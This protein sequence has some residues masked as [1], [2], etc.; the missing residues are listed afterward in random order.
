MYQL[1]RQIPVMGE[2]DILVAGAGPAG[3]CAAM[4]AARAGARVALVERH[5]TV[6]GNLTLGHVGPIMGKLNPD[7]MAGEI[8]DL[9]NGGTGMVHD[10]E[11]AKRR[12]MNW[13]DH[14]LIDLYLLCPVVD[15][16]MEAGQIK[17]LVVGTQSGMAAIFARIV[18]DCTGDGVVSH[19]A[20]AP[21]VMGREGD[22]LV[23]PATI[24]YTIAGIDPRQTM[25]CTHE[26]DE[27]ILPDGKSYLQLCRDACADGR[28]PE[29]VNIVRLYRCADDPAKR[30][31][32]ATQE[33]R[34]N[35]LDP[36]DMVRAERSLRNQCQQ[37]VTFLREN[38]WGF[39]HCYIES[40]AD[41]VGI[42]ES[43]RVL[44]EY[45]ICGEDLKYGM[46][47]PDPVVHDAFFCIDIHNPDGAGQ[48]ES[49]NKPFELEQYDLPYRAFVPLNVEGLYTCG[50]CISGTHRAHASYRVMNTVLAMG[51][52]IGT[53]AALCVQENVLPR[54][55]DYSLL[56]R[57][58]TDMGVHLGKEA[59]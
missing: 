56:R 2:Y 51:Q 24:M 26:A 57:A 32:N 46:Q 4:A 52:A 59:P 35:A 9:L 11:D 50:R 55:L 40:S 19:L 43:R 31:V 16:I 54:Q 28:L 36:Q 47:F 17:G 10:T 6:G 38:V 18:I 20:G 53:A 25:V 30:L 34:V 21:W 37:V 5:G 27:T 22:G 1:S 49:G 45:V 14:D 48:A 33:N 7:T 3:L 58:L 12:L 39:E 8:N 44:G 41:V 13:I 23:Q 15:A 29:N 42:R